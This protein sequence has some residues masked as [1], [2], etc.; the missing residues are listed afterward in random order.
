M[1]FPQI[2]RRFCFGF[3]I[4]IALL[5]LTRLC[6]LV[7]AYYSPTSAYLV[8]GGTPNRERYA[9]QL[10]KAH[11]DIKVLISGGS[12]NPCIWLIFDKEKT[13]KDNVWM[14]RCS[15]N[16][17]DNFYYSAPILSKWGVRK[18]LLITDPPQ[19]DRVLPMA[20]IMLGAKGMWVDLCIVPNSGGQDSRY[21]MWVDI[22]CSAAWAIVSQVI[23]PKCS[24]FTYLP[25]V[26]MEYWYKKGF[27]CA[28]QAE[29][30]NYRPK[31]K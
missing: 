1:K 25:T 17:F 12:E 7:I 23:E 31:L 30:D 27:Y 26:D 5:V 3:G 8:L 11:P 13:P 4:G 9:A 15:H 20:K 22:A 2:F 21:P 18:V 16:T 28:P 19:S 24:S 10:V 29:V 14:E 6:Q